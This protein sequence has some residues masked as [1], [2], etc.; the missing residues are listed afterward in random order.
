M[1]GGGGSGSSRTADVSIVCAH[2]AS[3]MKGHVTG[4]PRMDHDTENFPVS[5]M[6]RDEL[7]TATV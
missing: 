2:R 4:I 5:L 6:S 7:P 3:R 1:N